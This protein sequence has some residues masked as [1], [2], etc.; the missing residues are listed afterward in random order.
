MRV[1][2]VLEDSQTWKHLLLSQSRLQYGAGLP[3]YG[4]IPHQRGTGLPG[5]GGYARQRGA[6]LGSFFRGLFRMAMP[7]IKRA[8]KAVGK[9]AL[10][11]GVSVLADVARGGDALP[12]LETH[13]REAVATL[14]DQTLN[15]LNKHPS[16]EQQGGGSSKRRRRSA[17]RKTSGSSRNK[18]KRPKPRR[19]RRLKR[20]RTKRKPIKGRR[21]KA[22]KKGKQKRRRQRLQ[23]PADIFDHVAG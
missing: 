13:G 18:K 7:V 21:R 8:A 17:S 15:Y 19:R 20:K 1:P 4:G 9:Q 3:G 2:Y 22:T 5:Y 12:S 16:T 6:G 10:K 14:A 23:H 11:T